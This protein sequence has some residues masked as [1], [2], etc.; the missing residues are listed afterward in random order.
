MNT[1][2]KESINGGEANRWALPVIALG[3]I[4]LDTVWHQRTGDTRNM[5]QRAID[6]W[7]NEGGEIPNEQKN[8]TQLVKG[9]PIRPAPIPL[10]FRGK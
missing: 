7:E 5:E 8:R 2:N 10:V 9:K 3:N 1:F 6:R 4:G